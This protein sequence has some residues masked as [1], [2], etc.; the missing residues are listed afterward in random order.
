[1]AYAKLYGFAGNPRTRA[2][3]VA[4]KFEG[5][6]LE[7][8]E[9]NPVADG[10]S[11][12]YKAKFP[13]GLIPALE[14]DDFKLTEATA[15]ATYIASVENKAGL[16]GATKE[17]AAS[18][19][20]WLSWGNYHLLRVTG[21]WFAPL[22][23]RKPYN[24]T[25]VDAAKET[26]LKNLDYLNK[27]LAD[28]TFLVGHRITLADI[29]VTS[30]LYRGTEFVLDTEIRAAY[31]NVFR[32][33]NTVYH[34]PA[35]LSVAGEPTLIAKTVVFTPPKKDAP[36]KKEAP[37]KEAAAPKPKAAAEEEEEPAA[38][39][40]PKAKHP[41]ELLGNAKSFPLDEFKRQYS[42]NETPDAFKWLEEHFDPQEYSL[43]KVTYKYPEE[44]TQV[45]MS[46]NLIGGFHSRLE[47]SRKYLFGSNAVYGVSNDSKIAGAYM[48][49]G[50]DYKSIFDVAPDFE[51]Y[52]YAPL[53]IKA[54]RDFIL[55]CWAWDNSFE[56]KPFADA[57]VFK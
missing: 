24:K 16:L 10:A 1:M 50:S 18:V 26:T 11:E 12:E 6:D 30:V 42:N 41:A 23:G 31:P 9:T 57:K 17:E 51:S 45:F 5:L 39:A 40:E 47:A 48:I 32:L 36:A 25:A 15:V 29:F 54:D 55:G 43:W 38:P 13:L 34:Q 8:V 3:L 14:K 7:L 20:Q 19:Q 2:S 27:T 33:F 46:A 37:K 35:F 53:D 44:L 4:A 21:D 52:D 49:R 22:I 28:R 56:G